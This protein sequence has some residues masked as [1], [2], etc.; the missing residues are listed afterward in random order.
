MLKPPSP[1]TP[2][3][4][5][6][7]VALLGFANFDREGLAAHL[8]L[9]LQRNPPYV[10]A[11]SAA[12]ADF[13]VADAEHAES[14]H[15][16]VRGGRLR[17]TVFIGQH[18]PE[19]AVACLRRPIDPL[20]VLRE[21]DAV[22]TLRAAGVPTAPG[23]RPPAALLV[24]DSDIALRFLESRLQRLGL[25]TERA[26]NSAQAMQR[27]EQRRFDFLFLDVELGA[28]SEL[29]GLTLC[30]RIKRQAPSAAARPPV[31]AIISAHQSEL[32]RA[33]GTLAGC[34]A[35]MGKPLDEPALR[36][37]LRRHGAI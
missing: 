4:A 33:R 24:D 11:D 25:Q 13:M 8:R 3:P 29:D 1:P 32:D 20:H 34:D 26:V 37:L 2:I 16:I 17:D 5:P 30:Q 12:A 27:L 18:A 14:V 19:G 15:E 6:Y 31:I 21:L 7:R 36:T 10:L 9:A 28:D 22:V 35:Y 23:R